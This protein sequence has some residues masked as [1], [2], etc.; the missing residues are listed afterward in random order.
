MQNYLA[1]L[2]A[3]Q[4]TQLLKLRDAIHSAAP[5]AV[6]SFGYGMPAFALDGKNFIWFGA[7]KNHISFYPI[8]EATRRALTHEVA[9]YDTSGKGTI[10][11]RSDENLPASLIAKLVKARIAELP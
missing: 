1:K 7:W 10:R 2:P 11:F 4:R 6:E 9:G 3:S 5:E 8:S